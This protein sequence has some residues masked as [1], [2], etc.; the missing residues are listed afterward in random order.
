MAIVVPI[1]SAWDPKGLD[2]AIKE[3]KKA[4]GT[5]N[6]I[7]RAA[8]IMSAS[9]IDTGR[10]LTRNVTVPLAALGIAVNKTI[11]DASRLQ[12]AQSKVTAVFKNQAGEVQKWANVRH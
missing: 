12:E 3:I 11:N 1:V 4:E 5:F 10:S 2:R 8:N 7:S 6:T 9:F